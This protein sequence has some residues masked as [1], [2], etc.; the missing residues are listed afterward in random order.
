MSSAAAETDFL[1]AAETYRKL[2]DDGIRNGPLFYNLGTALVLAKRHEEAAASLLRAE[3]YMGGAW[4]VQRNLRIALAG[5]RRDEAAALPWQRVPLFW[6]Y[7]LKLSTR[8]AVAA[9]AFSI[10]WLSLTLRVLGVTRVGR[11]M[12]ALSLAALILFGSSAAATLH[13]E[14]SDRQTAPAL[15]QPGADGGPSARTASPA[16]WDERGGA[17][18]PDAGKERAR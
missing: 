17:P 12:M 18:R 15:T 3:R 2:V 16:A 14:W 11:R 6:H 7:G 5:E 9:V 10:F 13:A 1:R 4:E 8:L